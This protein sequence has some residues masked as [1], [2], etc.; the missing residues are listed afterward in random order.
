MTVSLLE[1][2]PSTALVIWP[3]S[4]CQPLWA[5][6]SSPESPPAILNHLQFPTDTT[7]FHACVP[8]I[9]FPFI[10]LKPAGTWNFNS[11]IMSASS[12]PC[13]TP[14]SVWLSHASPFPG[15]PCSWSEWRSGLTWSETQFKPSFSEFLSMDVWQSISSSELQFLLRTMGRMGPP[16][17][18]YC[19]IMVRVRAE[20]RAGHTITT[21]RV[22]FLCLHCI[23][24]HCSDHV[25]LSFANGDEAPWGSCS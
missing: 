17:R 11:R 3:L 14:H 9:P 1:L 25:I 4:A 5:P 15:Y 2:L 6:F 16:S 18:G 23:C 24:H 7:L 21:Q 8:G 20:P 12:L 19:R 10:C 22:A 13:P